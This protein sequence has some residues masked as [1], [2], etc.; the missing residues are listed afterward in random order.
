[1]IF[2]WSSQDRHAYVGLSQRHAGPEQEVN[3]PGPVRLSPGCHM[4]I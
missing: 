2:K 3:L 1:M 4:T